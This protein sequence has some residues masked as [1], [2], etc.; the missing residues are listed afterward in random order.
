MCNLRF[1]WLVVS[2]Y[3]I[4]HVPGIE[5][6]DIRITPGVDKLDSKDP[7]VLP[8]ETPKS[9]WGPDAAFFL[10]GDC[11]VGMSGTTEYKV[12]PFQ[13]V[14]QKRSGSSRAVLLGVWNEWEIPE[15]AHAKFHDPSVLSTSMTLLNSSYVQ[16]ARCGGPKNNYKSTIV[17][18]KCLN[19]AVARDV[20]T[21]SEAVASEVPVT[22]FAVMDIEDKNACNYYISFGFPLPCSLLQYT[23]LKRPV[24]IQSDEKEAEGAWEGAADAAAAA[25]TDSAPS[26]EHSTAATDA[27]STESSTG[28]DE[29]TQVEAVLSNINQSDQGTETGSMSTAQFSAL[30]TEVCYSDSLVK[31]PVV[32]LHIYWLAI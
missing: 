27:S 8:Y 21:G 7:N 24:T 26:G 28:L 22:E 20:T 32:R 3:F 15:S 25:Q 5:S 6:K 29:I 12:C 14:T 9:Y 2:L 18:F 17:E 10:N 31:F 1:S 4:A 30:M 11:F 16:G 23:H 13:N 19:P